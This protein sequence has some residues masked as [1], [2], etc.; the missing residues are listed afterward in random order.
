MALI[1]CKEC[2]HEVSDKADKCPNCG[3]PVPKKSSAGGVVIILLLGL[4]ALMYVLFEVNPA[5][6]RDASG[7][8]Q[9][10]PARAEDQGIAAFIMCQSFAEDHL[11]SP[12]SARWPINPRVSRRIGPGERYRVISHVDAQN[13]FGA[14]IRNT[15]TCEIQHT[16]DGDW[17]LISMSIE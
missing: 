2:G 15:M 6:E 16:G 11:R 4:T 8:G 17:R 3:A 12:R 10:Q 5:A 9:P 14:E 13:A 1:K 7:Q